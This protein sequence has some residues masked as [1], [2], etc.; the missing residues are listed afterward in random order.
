[1]PPDVFVQ[2][3]DDAQKQYTILERVYAYAREQA[4]DQDRDQDRAT[5]LE[6]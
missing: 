5:S 4:F 6:A 3:V 1:M 2:L